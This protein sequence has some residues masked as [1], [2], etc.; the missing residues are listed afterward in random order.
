MGQLD[1]HFDKTG[2]VFQCVILKRLCLVPF[3][4][5]SGS[6]S[7]LCVVGKLRLMRT[8]HSPGLCKMQG[9][10]C[11]EDD[12]SYT[13]P[14]FSSPPPA[15]SL[16]EIDKGSAVPEKAGYGPEGA[17]RKTQCLTLLSHFRAVWKFLP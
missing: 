1:Q 8:K 12:I 5:T 4:E 13:A 9:L 6:W 11:S 10:D 15:Q 17:F 3:L 14:E 16:S 2:S 7:F